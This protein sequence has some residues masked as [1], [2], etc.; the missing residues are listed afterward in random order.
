LKASGFSFY[1]PNFGNSTQ[2]TSEKRKKFTITNYNLPVFS[3]DPSLG[4]IFQFL[5][6]KNNFGL[7]LDKTCQKT[8][9]KVPSN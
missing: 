7:S 3:N 2:I 8:T 5:L 4:E 9:V 6:A 1:F